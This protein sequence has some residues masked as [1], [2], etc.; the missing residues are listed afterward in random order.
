METLP[1]DPQMPA[2]TVQTADATLTALLRASAVLH[3]HL[4]PRQ[5]LGVRM[6]MWA[7]ELLGIPLPQT[8]KRVLAIVESDG[9]FSTGVSVAMNCWVGRRTMRVEDFGKTAL[10]VVDTVTDVAWRIAPH[11]AARIQAEAYAPEAGS[12]WEAMLLGY[13]RMPTAALLTAQAVQLN[14]PVA[15]LISKPGH[16]VICATCGEEILN[17]REVARD[18]VL[19]CRACAGAAY[20]TVTNY[21]GTNCGATDT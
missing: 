11:P 19:L 5:V 13:Q 12:R 4:C 17:E 10:T 15:E 9:C 3:S 21:R 2:H 18:G 20:Y 1:A 7:A 14:T 16:R 6:G 8:E